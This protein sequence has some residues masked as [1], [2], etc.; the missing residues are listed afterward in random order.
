VDDF[1]K[2]LEQQEATVIKA[3][4]A[5][6]KKEDREYLKYSWNCLK[7]KQLTLEQFTKN[8]NNYASRESHN[9]A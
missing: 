9:G 1:K 5:V 7:N 3:I 4:Q 2:I 8:L 6:Q